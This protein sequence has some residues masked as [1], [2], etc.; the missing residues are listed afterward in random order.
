M[1]GG[2]KRFLA[3]FWTFKEYYVIDPILVEIKNYYIHVVKFSAR[4]SNCRV[5]AQK[6]NY[7]LRYECTKQGV[8]CVQ[9][10]PTSCTL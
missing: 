2:S 4:A 10:N 6:T 3:N 9:L 5:I 8:I 1:S 7:L